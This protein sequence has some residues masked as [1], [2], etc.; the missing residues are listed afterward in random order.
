MLDNRLGNMAHQDKP[1]TVEGEQDVSRRL[2]MVQS[3]LSSITS[4][5]GEMQLNKT[6]FQ[7]QVNDL[8]RESGGVRNSKNELGRV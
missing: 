5:L 8:R 7:G 4:L 3:Q 1:A 2:G 6:C